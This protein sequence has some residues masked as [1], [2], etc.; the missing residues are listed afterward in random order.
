MGGP[1]VTGAALDL[2]PA[3]AG[4]SIADPS[5][6]YTG[7]YL[8]AFRFLASQFCGVFSAFSQSDFS[9]SIIFWRR[10]PPPGIAAS[11]STMAR[12]M[13]A[14]CSSALSYYLTDERTVEK[15]PTSASG[16]QGRGATTFKSLQFSESR[17]KGERLSV[18][19]TC[20]TV[21]M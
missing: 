19:G 8:P 13:A 9:C 6:P 18:S 12:W 4:W 17:S 10:V 15:F 5:E 21:S 1:S 7:R 2:S 3:A 14:A 11:R 20:H 16:R